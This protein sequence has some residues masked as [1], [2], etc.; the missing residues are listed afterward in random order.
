MHF[1]K[2]SLH[3]WRQ[4]SSV[5]IAFHRRLT[6]VTGANGAGK[7]TLLNLLSRHFGWNVNLVSTPRSNG[8]I[9]NTTRYSADFWNPEIRAKLD[10]YLEH[11]LHVTFDDVVEDV[12][13][14][15]L[16]KL[17][18]TEAVSTPSNE[19]EIGQILYSN[20]PVA[21]LKVPVTGVG[22]TYQISIHNQQPVSG[23]HIS[24]HRPI[25]SYQ[26]VLSIPTTPRKRDTLYSVY[27]EIIRQRATGQHHQFTP[28]YFIKETLIA[29][30][31][32]GFGNEFVV[33]D[34]DSREV[35]ERFQEILTK[36][37]PPK[38]QFQ[39]LSIRIPE[40]VVVTKSGEFSI[41]AASG[42]VASIIDVAWQICMFSPTEDAF[43]VTIDEPE[44]HLH[45]ELQRSF[46]PNLLDAFPKVQFIVASHNP[47][48]VSSV[49]DSNVYVLNYNEAQRIDSMLLDTVNRAGSSNEILRDVLGLDFTM[50]LWV[51]KRLEDLVSEF[52]KQQLT[53]ESLNLL[54]QRMAELGPERY[55]PDTISRIAQHH[56]ESNG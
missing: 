29:L 50:P 24:S 2:L 22:S 40:V 14:E 17:M 3:A 19:I 18:E 20:G 5:D 33:A 52:Q 8:A 28:N 21:Q 49:P 34:V 47:F 36:V 9:T 1:T 41:D 54:R 45:P 7:T 55:I 48:M 25:F 32:W 11:H 13:E 15:I 31:M 23:I 35:F 53:Q 38:L 27:N 42:G 51:E 46:L 12:L 44:N 56:I 26:P 39:K 43:V 30:A 37:L 6:V 10:A 4:F 16:I